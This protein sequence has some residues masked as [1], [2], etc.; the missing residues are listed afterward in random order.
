M[1][2][3]WIRVA[4]ACVWMASA[5]CGGLGPIVA[6]V[7]PGE[8]P[9]GIPVVILGSG[10]GTETDDVS[11]T[12]GGAEV[13]EFL[14]H[15][16]T[17]ITALVPDGAKT[18]PVI[19]TVNG[20][21]SG[22]D[23]I[24][25]VTDEQ[26]GQSGRRLAILDASPA[27]GVYAYKDE[28]TQPTEVTRRSLSESG[29]ENVFL[30]IVYLSGPKRAAVSA[31]RRAVG[32]TDETGYLVLHSISDSVTD[33]TVV[34]LGVAP[35]A[36]AAHPEG[37]S[38]Y[39][40][41]A[42]ATH[43]FSVDAFSGVAGPVA[44]MNLQAVSPYLSPTGLAVLASPDEARFGSHLVAVVGT[45]WLQG[46]SE[47]I[48]FA[49]EAHAETDQLVS[50]IGIGGLFASGGLSP[51]P[52]TNL[53][54][55]TGD[56][57]GVGCV[58]AVDVLRDTAYVP[59]VLDAGALTGLAEAV[60]EA[61]SV[62]AVAQARSL[63]VAAPA[64]GLLA[65][66][67]PEPVSTATETGYRY[68]VTAPVGDAVARLLEIEG[69]PGILAP[70]YDDLGILDSALLSVSGSRNALLRVDPDSDEPVSTFLPLPARPLAIDSVP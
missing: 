6:S 35:V 40:V 14:S 28:S 62:L 31:S 37:E 69:T 30:D 22:A 54:F 39:V 11:V 7:T 36:L 58:G 46:G 17:A 1:K 4:T 61:T 19:V 65:F 8:G 44:G 33:P 9:V 43:V 68:D 15:T 63:L 29:Y 70:H 12:I 20:S 41:Q 10:F 67:L 47:V 57:E 51:F 32:S 18:G 49:P 34:D 13:P 16:D 48:T 64:A 5:A 45:N 38:I 59:L 24:F 3:L 27:L 23:V 50:Q 66:T 55:F 60:T 53:L 52:P 56:C 42:G 2:S 25:T 21:S 26:L